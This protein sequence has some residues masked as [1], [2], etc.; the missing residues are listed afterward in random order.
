MCRPAVYPRCPAV[1]TEPLVHQWDDVFH[2]QG[3]GLLLTTCYK[4]VISTKPLIKIDLYMP[5]VSFDPP[6]LEA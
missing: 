4:Q 3:H 1:K 6:V 2:V 5:T